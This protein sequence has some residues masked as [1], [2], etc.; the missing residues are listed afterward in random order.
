MAK[1]R[2]G[3]EAAAR[4]RR[5][6]AAYEMARDLALALPGVTE[7]KSFGMPAFKV[8]GKLIARLREDGVSMVLR[9]GFPEREELLHRSPD[10]FYVAE[11]QQGSP[12]IVVRLTKVRR[13]VLAQL[14]TDTWR[15]LVPKIWLTRF[16]ADPVRRENPSH[17][18][19]ATTDN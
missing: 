19:D 13:N 1:K 5:G 4:K 2:R 11:N 7:A 8:R 15:R 12:A 9:V 6:G 16:D 10:A 17:H 18:P 14:F 3:A